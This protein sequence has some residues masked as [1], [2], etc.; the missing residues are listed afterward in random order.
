MVACIEGAQ[1]VAE[2]ASPV[3]EPRETRPTLAKLLMM[4]QPSVVSGAW[5]Q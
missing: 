5:L 4:R 2:A 3:N 1:P